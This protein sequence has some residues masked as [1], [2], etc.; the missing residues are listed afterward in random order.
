M[1]KRIR[2]T[3]QEA[4]CGLKFP[5]KTIIVCLNVYGLIRTFGLSLS[6]D[7]F[8]LFPIKYIKMLLYYLQ[9]WKKLFLLIL[10]AQMKW[11]QCIRGSFVAAH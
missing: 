6:Y 10:W 11:L 8:K 4:T 7:Y 2:K 9:I 1:P 5:S 3:Q